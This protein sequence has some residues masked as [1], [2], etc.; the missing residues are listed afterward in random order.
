MERPKEDSFEVSPLREWLSRVSSPPAFENAFRNSPLLHV[1]SS[2]G[3]LL[4]EQQVPRRT[5]QYQRLL[6]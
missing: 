2:V 3:P 4:S 1:G 5:A 6:Q